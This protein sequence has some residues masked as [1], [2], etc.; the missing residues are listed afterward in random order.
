MLGSAQPTGVIIQGPT[1]KTEHHLGHETRM[2]EG[3]N[4]RA[5]DPPPHNH[6]HSYPWPRQH[7][8][9]I[10]FPVKIDGDI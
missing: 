4:A 7:A 3:R 5:P 1:L 9:Y 8:G 6:I 10:H 2:R